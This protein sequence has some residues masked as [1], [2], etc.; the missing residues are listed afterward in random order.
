MHERA[1]S[2]ARALPAVTE[3]VGD[4]LN[5]LADFG[6]RSGLDALRMLA[7]AG[8]G[9]L[10]GHIYSYAFAAAGQANVARLLST[11]EEEMRGS[12]TPAASPSIDSMDQA[13][14]AESH[15]AP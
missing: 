9:V 12:L 8:K 4:N 5:A 15:R 11:I 13:P 1:Q 14:L 7:L 6:V 10:L 3:A 2:I